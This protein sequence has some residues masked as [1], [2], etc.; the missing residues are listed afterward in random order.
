MA[1]KVLHT[2]DRNSPTHMTQVLR[3]VLPNYHRLLYNYREK[4]RTINTC[5]NNQRTILVKVFGKK[6]IWKV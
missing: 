3:I 6:I 4:V 5:I 2:Y 1:R